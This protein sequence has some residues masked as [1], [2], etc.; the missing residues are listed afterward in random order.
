MTEPYSAKRGPEID[1]D[2][3]R[4]PD[5]VP[6]VPLPEDDYADGYSVGDPAAPELDIDP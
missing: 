3:N 2:P 6:P 5:Q 4:D 1:I